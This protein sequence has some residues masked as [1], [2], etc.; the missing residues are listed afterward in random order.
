MVIHVGFNK[1]GFASVSKQVLFHFER[2][3]LLLQ[4]L[5]SASEFLVEVFLAVVLEKLVVVVGHGQEDCPVDFEQVV[6]HLVFVHLHSG[7]HLLAHV[8]VLYIDFRRSLDKP[9]QVY[10][11]RVSP[12]LQSLFR[13]NEVVW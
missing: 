7:E 3:S 8:S 10:A 13:G 4:I 5:E 1:H 9:G 12:Y 11:H 6:Q 2:D